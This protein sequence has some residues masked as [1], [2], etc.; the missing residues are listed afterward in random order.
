MK[1]TRGQLELFG[2]LPFS[3]RMEPGHSLIDDA[4]PSAC[5]CGHELGPDDRTYTCNI[6]SCECCDQCSERRDGRRV[7]EECRDV[8]VAD[9]R[10]CKALEKYLRGHNIPFVAVTEAKKAIFSGASLDSFDCLIYSES[11]PNLL[12]LLTNSPSTAGRLLI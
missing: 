10:T 12:V 5:D 8:R 1:Q 3:E 7:C 6:C 2:S 11:G 4:S 9:L